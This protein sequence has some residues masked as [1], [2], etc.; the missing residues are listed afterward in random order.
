M[1]PSQPFAVLATQT[2]PPYRRYAWLIVE[3]LDDEDVPLC[4]SLGTFPTLM[5]ALYAGQQAL[6]Q[7]QS[8]T[9]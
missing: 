8:E 6:H 5:S 4:E 3:R 1:S 7:M 9:R 2:P